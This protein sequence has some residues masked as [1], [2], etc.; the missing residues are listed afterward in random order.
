MQSY[1]TARQQV[2]DAEN[3]LAA[4]RSEY[5]RGNHD[6]AELI[7]QAEKQLSEAKGMLTGLRNTVISA[8]Q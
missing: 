6:N 2:A 1:L 8:E 5:S 3:K 4:M 7:R